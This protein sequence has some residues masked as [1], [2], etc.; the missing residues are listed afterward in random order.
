MKV[1]SSIAVCA[2]AEL[3]LPFGTSVTYSIPCMATILGDT[4]FPVLI[5]EGT[6]SQHDLVKER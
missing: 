1:V 3:G 4:S 2:A 6:V 5:P